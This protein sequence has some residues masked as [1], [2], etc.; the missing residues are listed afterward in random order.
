MK[1]FWIKVDLKTDE[2]VAV[3]DT[4]RELAKICGVKEETIRQRISRAKKSGGKCC[5]M[6]MEDDEQE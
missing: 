5:Y 1:H 2:I 6:R 4:Q 3:A